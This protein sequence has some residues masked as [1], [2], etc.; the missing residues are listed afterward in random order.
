MR[1]RGR[2]S[3]T[4]VC[5]S[6]G[7][8]TSPNAIEPFQSARAIRTA[9][10]KLNSQLARM[11]QL[12]TLDGASLTD[13]HPER[14]ELANIQLGA[15][16]GRARSLVSVPPGQVALGLDPVVEIAAVA[17]RHGSGIAGTR[18]GRCRRRSAGTRTLPRRRPCPALHRLA[19]RGVTLATSTGAAAGASS[20]LLVCGGG[21]A[22]RWCACGVGIFLRHVKLLRG[23]SRLSPDRKHQLSARHC[24]KRATAL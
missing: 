11:H 17:I 13:E 15:I 8:L 20:S 6:T 3:R 10:C 24:S 7:M 14:W 23:L 18:P 12:P 2:E 9:R 21:T 19:P 5:S 4:A 16:G 1:K 22:R